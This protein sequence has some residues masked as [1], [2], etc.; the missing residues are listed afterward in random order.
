MQDKSYWLDNRFFS[1]NTTPMQLADCC[2]DFTD[3]IGTVDTVS[4][5][6]VTRRSELFR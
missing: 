4:V 6:L 1:A 3:V 2:T 5:Q